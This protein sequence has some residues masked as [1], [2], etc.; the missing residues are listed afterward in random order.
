MTRNLR[1]LAA[2]A[3]TL[4]V[5][6]A[7][8]PVAGANHSGLEHISLGP[9]GGNG[10]A[11]VFMDGV[12][13]DGLRAF[14]DTD[15][16]LV[17]G[18]TDSSFDLYERKGGTTTLLSTGPNGGNGA[19]DVFFSANSVDGTRVFFM[20]DESL[21]STDT[22]TFFDI[23]ER[24]G[25]V[26]TLVSTGPSGGNGPND[27]IFHDIS[28]TGTRVFFETEEQLVSG[29][30]DAQP[31][32]YERSGGTT[33]HLSTG[34]GGGN[35]A[36]VPSWGG[37]SADG[38]RVFLETD[39]S[40]VGTDTDAAADVYER[41]GST[42][43]LLSTGTA[44]G[45]GNFDA[46]YRENSAD[47]SHVF[48]HTAES[49]VTG[50]TD[51][52]TDVYDRSGGTTTRISTGP[53]GGNGALP[54]A[55]E[56]ASSDGT[57]VFFSTSES[58]LASD[59]DARKDIYSRSGST[60]AHVSNG[61]A[62][63]NGLFDAD[64]VGASATGARAYIQ[65]EEALVAGDTDTGCAGGQG[66]QCRDVYEYASGTTTRVSTG[67]AG[68]NGAFDV[69]FAAVSADGARVFFHT[70]ETMTASDTD[71]A[72]DVYERFSG[73]T[74]HISTGPAGGNGAFNAFTF[75]TWMSNDGT[76]VFFDTAESLMASDT[77]SS[78]DIYASSVPTYSRPL[79]AP[80]LR[81]SLVPAF[82]QCTAPNR[83]HGPPLSGGSCSPPTGASAHASTGGTGGDP[84]DFIGSLRYSVQ[85]GA[86]GPPE[87]SDVKIRATLADVRCKTGGANC[88]SAN[89]APPADYTGELRA[90]VVVRTTDR[91][92]AAAPGGGSDPA[93]SQ[94]FVLGASFACVQTASTTMG[95][96]CT[97]NTSANAI[98]A[99]LVKDEKR[100]VWELGQAQIYDGG[101]DGDGDTVAGNTV[102]AVQGVFVP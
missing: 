82:N 96:S 45:N 71:G 68:G 87:D 7:M 6:A 54:A 78:F 80:S 59:T 21:V 97:V 47:G 99:G 38:T 90:A 101:P 74:T 53:G 81:A 34:P 33:S 70:R 63:G 22:D 8:A 28:S 58:V 49:L 19:F 10:V 60:T 32:L 17:A 46:G 29:D 15:E 25:G 93:T 86:S 39:E 11:D 27:V 89:T 37:A 67:P 3:V 5:L 73:T 48:F 94:D 72:D 92:N 50:D 62:G 51:A 40:L 12:S 76:R 18:D 9:A 77:D 88:G 66:P 36:N 4:A 26:T 23:Y 95:S 41:T 43:T 85:E 1:R 20:T 64:F 69:S 55:F 75:E 16:Q 24:A 31:D 30:T 52:Q 98:T 35:G 42:T 13:G 91:W 84:T 79:V 83:T 57:L 102:F 61:S 65:T 100:A 2:T 56:G 14:F 44:G